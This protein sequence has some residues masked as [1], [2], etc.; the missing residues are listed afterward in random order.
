MTVDVPQTVTTFHRTFGQILKNSLKVKDSFK[1][2]ATLDQLTHISGHNWHI[3][4]EKNSSTQQRLIGLVTIH[5][6][7]KITNIYDKSDC[8]R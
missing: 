1:S 8:F 6:R 2:S 4:A 7:P 3:Y 5:H